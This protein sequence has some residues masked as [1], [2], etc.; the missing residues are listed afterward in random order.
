MNQYKELM[1]LEEYKTRLD[2]GGRYVGFWIA[3]NWFMQH[4]GREIVETGCVRQ[5][6]DFEGAGGST[7]IFG[8]VAK[9]AGETLEGLHHGLH[10][11]FTTIDNDPAHLETARRICEGLPVNY[12]LGDSAETL[13]GLQNNIDLLYLDS[14]DCDATPGA[15][16]VEPQEHNRREMLV[17]ITKLSPRGVLVLDDNDFENGGKTRL[18]NEYLRSAGLWAQLWDGKQAVWVRK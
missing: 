4:G 18:S 5:D 17:G 2:K 12:L 8:R 10:A 7:Y 6:D 9:D 15:A 13:R 16:N 3:L 11:H 14:L 1:V